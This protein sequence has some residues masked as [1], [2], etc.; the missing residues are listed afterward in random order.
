VTECPQ[1]F[2][3]F[4]SDGDRIVPE[5]IC[6]AP[7]RILTLE[8]GDTY[9]VTFEWTAETTTF[10]DGTA[11]RQPLAPGRYALRGAVV[12]SEYGVL[13]GGLTSVDVLP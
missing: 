1:P 13:V 6:S 3:V 12:S 7:A 4:A 8:R 9:S 5:E 11:V 10:S 2:H